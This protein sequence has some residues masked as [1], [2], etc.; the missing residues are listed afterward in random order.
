MHVEKVVVSAIDDQL[1]AV[2]PLYADRVDLGERA[3]F[4][5]EIGALYCLLRSVWLCRCLVSRTTPLA[6]RRR[7]VVIDFRA[8]FD[9]RTE[10]FS[11]LRRPCVRRVF[12]K[13]ANNP[14]VTSTRCLGGG[15]T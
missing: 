9:R 2:G 15:A 1:R 6:R 7:V 13:G 14:G 11:K 10:G 12:I 3:G 8:C 5:D 4:G